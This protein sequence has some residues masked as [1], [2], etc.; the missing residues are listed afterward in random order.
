MGNRIIWKGHAREK[1]IPSHSG[2]RRVVQPQ[3]PLQILASDQNLKTLT[4]FYAG[5]RSQR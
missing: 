4:S 5:K 1:Y 3:P 2:V